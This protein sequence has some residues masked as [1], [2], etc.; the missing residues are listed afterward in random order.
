MGYPLV[1]TPVYALIDA[2][3]DLL[4]KKGEAGYFAPDY[5]KFIFHPYVKNIYLDKSAEPTR[6]IFQTLEE[7]ISSRVNK[8]I[9][10]AEIEK[11]GDILKE[12]AAKLK[13]YGRGLDA[14]AVQAH[15]SLIHKTLIGPFEEIKDIGDFA[16]KL[17]AFISYISGHSTAPLDTYLNCGLQFYYKYA[18]RLSEKDE[19][20]D[21][22][23]QRDIGAMV[24]EILENFFKPRIGKPLA[25]IE[26]DYKRI[27]EEAGKV[28]DVRLKGHNAGYEYLIKRQ[29]EKRLAEILDYHRANLAGITILA[30]E[31]EL[32]ASLPTKYG[33]ITLKGRADRVDARGSCVHILDYKTGTLARVPNWASVVSR[34]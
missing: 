1:S 25:I 15:I 9:K 26:A 29:V 14:G 11:D 16:S 22:I 19:L 5:L 10:L 27:L 30:C 8:Y 13:G 21:D 6:V 3:A 33:D 7:H 31:V 2:L 32:K 24:H 12:A 17:L 18:L 23:G 4:D 20:S 28:F 34:K